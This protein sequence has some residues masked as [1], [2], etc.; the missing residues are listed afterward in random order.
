M[1]TSQKQ[2]N[3]TVMP[4]PDVTLVSDGDDKEVVNLEAVARVATSDAGV[5]GRTG[6]EPVRTVNRTVLTR[7]AGAGQPCSAQ[8]RFRF[9]Q[10]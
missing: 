7:T 4:V 3:A 6:S 2:S 1:S 10:N 9:S 8:G 5:Q